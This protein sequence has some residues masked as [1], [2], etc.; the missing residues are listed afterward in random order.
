MRG[1]LVVLYVITFYVITQVPTGI[2]ANDQ[3]LIY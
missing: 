1:P 2:D 3:Y